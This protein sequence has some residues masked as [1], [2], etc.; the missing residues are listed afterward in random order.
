[1]DLAKPPV[2]S[3]RDP[4]QENHDEL[5]EWIGTDLDPDN[6]NA[7][8]FNEVVAGACGEMSAQAHDTVLD[9][10]CAVDRSCYRLTE[11]QR[12]PSMGAFT[13]STSPHYAS[14]RAGSAPHLSL[15]EAAGRKNA[16]LISER[17][18]FDV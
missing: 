18:V 8:H 10:G 3:V 13:A 9:A 16:A 4:T 17:G 2:A 11:A 7:A 14:L 5:T 6:D 1:M 12:N 15:L